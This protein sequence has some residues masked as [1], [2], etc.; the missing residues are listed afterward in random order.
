MQKLA[1]I[2]CLDDHMLSSPESTVSDPSRP[3]NSY[4]RWLRYGIVVM[5]DCIPSLGC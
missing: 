2:Q 3:G 5:A 4:C 1:G